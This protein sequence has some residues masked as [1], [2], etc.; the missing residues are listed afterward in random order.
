MN[1]IRC[2]LRPVLAASAFCFVIL[3]PDTARADVTVTVN[4]NTSQGS[5]KNIIGLNGW[6]ATDP[7]VAGNSAYQSSLASINTSFF[8][9]HAAEIL[10]PSTHSKSWLNSDGLTWN[11]SRIQSV[12]NGVSPRVG[13]II[14]N[15]PI[16]P[17][18]LA[19]TNAKLPEAKKAAFAAF[20]A[21]LAHIVRNQL[22][23]TKVTH[24]EILN[25][26]DNLYNGTSNTDE[27]YALCIQVRNAIRARTTALTLI[28]APFATPYDSDIDHLISK[29][30]KDIFS[31]FSY[32]HYCTA[33]DSTDLAFAYDRAESIGAKASNIRAK[34]NAVTNGTAIRL[35]V[36]ESNVYAVW[37]HDSLGYM[38]G[39]AGAVAVALIWRG[40]MQ[41]RVN[42]VI[43]TDSLQIWNDA[44]GNLRRHEPLRL[45]SASLRPPPSR[46]PFTLR[47]WHR[48]PDDQR[49]FLDSPLRR[50]QRHPAQCYARQPRLDLSGR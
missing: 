12:L 49:L 19:P 47:F 41:S 30:N 23:N 11:V 28:P 45:R 17:S 14:I 35:F 43:S 22:G 6:S 18:A 40:C 10:N 5:L 13:N 48:A 46:A 32:H 8:R 27:L 25:E 34:L 16:W 20:C 24:L 39:E 42:G 1:I 4:W 3:A 44:D 2:L 9:L 15:I 36:G 31:A 21:D 37:N 26:V 29:M 50:H 38:A 7:N 33:G